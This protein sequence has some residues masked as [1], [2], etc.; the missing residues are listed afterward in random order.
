ME[1][2]PSVE[3]T[4]R[5]T[6]VLIAD[7]SGST[8]LY[9][10]L[11]DRDAHAWIGGIVDRWSAIVRER[12]GHVVKTMGDGLLATLDDPAAASLAAVELH[13]AVDERVKE[14]VALNAYVAFHVGAVVERDGDIFGDAVN[15]T[16][17]LTELAKPRQ[18]LTTAET[19][20]HVKDR[21]LR[22]LGRMQV[23]GRAA[24]VELIEVVWEQHMVT[25]LVGGPASRTTGEAALELEAG[26]T[27]LVL[28][29]NLP[30]VR[31][32][33]MPY[34]ELVV[35]GERVSRL[36]AR[37]QLRQ[38]TFVLVDESSNGT[39]LFQ[40]GT[41]DRVLR[42]QECELGMEGMIGLG[43]PPVPG[44]GTTLIFRSITATP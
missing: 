40:P 1:L 27:R 6:S 14:G 36:H 30:E 3:T 43:E 41:P 20:S 38:S 37:I 11:G 4:S 7:L 21:T 22:P 28:G 19:A 13:R 17:R 24:E 33:R 39:H 44:A 35:D 26:T 12:G 9:E 5:T 16:A 10:R 2:T 34:N 23:R 8:A 42:H 29:R 31:V 25:T 18:I 15:V 32:G